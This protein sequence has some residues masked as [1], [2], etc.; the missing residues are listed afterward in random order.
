MTHMSDSATKT[1]RTTLKAKLT[2]VKKKKLVRNKNIENL[3]REINAIRTSLEKFWNW[4]GYLK[5]KLHWMG[6]AEV[7]DS[8]VH[9]LE[10]RS[11]QI[12]YSE[13]QKKERK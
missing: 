11:I 8:V 13:K 1:F 9:E 6:L 2:Y 7:E 12:I 3:S 5:L 4:K 10:D